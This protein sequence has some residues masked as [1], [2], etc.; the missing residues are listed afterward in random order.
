MVRSAPPSP[1]RPSGS[2]APATIEPLAPLGR[3]VWSSVQRLA[4][5]LLRGPC[6]SGPWIKL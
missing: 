6:S 3:R 2:G 5:N 1:S 4:D